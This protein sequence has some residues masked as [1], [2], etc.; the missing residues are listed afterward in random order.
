MSQ[1]KALFVGDKKDTQNPKTPKPQNPMKYQKSNWFV[2]R[3]SIYIKLEI[4]VN[5]NNKK[6]ER[7]SWIWIPSHD[8]QQATPNHTSLE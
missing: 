1:N 3:F 2:I 4:D 8:E 7:T 6:D 5:S